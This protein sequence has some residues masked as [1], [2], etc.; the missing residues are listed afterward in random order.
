MKPGI[1]LV[2]KS[3]VV[4][5]KVP[6]QEGFAGGFVETNLE[7][8]RPYR[9]LF[10]SRLLLLRRSQWHR[11]RRA[12]HVH[13]RN[14]NGHAQVA[15]ATK[16]AGNRLIVR[17]V[18]HRTHVHLKSHA[19]NGNSLI[20]EFGNQVVEPVGFVKIV[21]LASVVV[22][23]EF[24][25]RIGLSSSDKGFANVIL[26]HGGVLDQR[27]SKSG[28][29]HPVR[30]H[31]LSVVSHCLVDDIKGPNLAFSRCQDGVNEQIHVT[32]YRIHRLRRPPRGIEI[33]HGINENMAMNSQAISY[34]QI[35]HLIV[36]NEINIVAPLIRPHIA[37]G[38]VDGGR[39]GIKLS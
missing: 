17:T 8:L 20:E 27:T 33:G 6:Q 2:G 25:I 35:H 14:V 7:N 31:V 3:R 10:Q 21:L 38:Q 32:L 15:K 34:Q 24:D 16:V 30:V 37:V 9:R 29:S 19:V 22:Q 36:S 4:F 12:L 23:N 28:P 13:F 11:T 1:T 39:H 26:P 5:G 18:S